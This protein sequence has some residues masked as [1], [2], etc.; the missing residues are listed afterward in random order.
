MP[1]GE[2]LALSCQTVLTRMK[3]GNQVSNSGSEKV[4]H[5]V[6]H[7]SGSSRPWNVISGFALL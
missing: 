5:A 3:Y 2:E 1:V 6:V 7:V 4:L